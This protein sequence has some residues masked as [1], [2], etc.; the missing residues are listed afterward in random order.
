MRYELNA[1]RFSLEYPSAKSNI[2]MDEI[3]D[4][5]IRKMPLQ[6][7]AELQAEVIIR[8]NDYKR[9]ITWQPIQEDSVESLIMLF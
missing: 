4:R 7:T 6:I 2:R 1:D 9:E 8:L 3:S 5:I